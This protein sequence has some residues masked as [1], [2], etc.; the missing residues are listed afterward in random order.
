[1]QAIILAAGVG[2]KT[3]GSAAGSVTSLQEITVNDSK[4]ADNKIVIFLF[5]A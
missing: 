4:I 1:M 3:T 5:I 2:S